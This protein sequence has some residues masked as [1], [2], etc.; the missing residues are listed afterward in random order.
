MQASYAWQQATAANNIVQMQQPRAPKGHTQVM[1]PPHGGRMQGKPNKRMRQKTK[2][3]GKHEKG[4]PTQMPEIFFEAMPLPKGARE[5]PKSKGPI[6]G[7]RTVSRPT[8]EEERAKKKQ[9]Q[10]PWP[11]TTA[12]TQACPWTRERCCTGTPSRPHPW[13][14]CITNSEL[15]NKCMQREAADL[16]HTPIS[17][18]R[19]GRITIN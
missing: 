1:G 5:Y 15:C 18:R 17:C 7:Y 19:Q 13:G 4:Q 9:W 16:S 3:L 11:C 10:L 14:S 2:P 8:Q 6:P 12:W